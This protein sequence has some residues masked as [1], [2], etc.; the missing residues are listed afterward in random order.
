MKFPYKGVEPTKEFGG[1]RK[2]K[3]LVDRMKTKFGVVKK[4]RGY[5]IRSITDQAV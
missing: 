2:E 5:S 3:E 4:S 1:N